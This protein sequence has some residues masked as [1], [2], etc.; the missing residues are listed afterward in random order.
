MYSEINEKIEKSQ[1]GIARLRKINSILKELESEQEDLLQKESDLKRVLKKEDYDLEK[2]EKKSIASLFYSILGSL[3]EHVEKERREALSA[4]LRYDQAIKDLENVKFQISKLSSERMDYVNCQAEY[5]Q[6]CALKKEE[7]I[8]EN[9]ET[10]KRIF[11]LSNKLNYAKINLKEIEEAIASGNEV[12]N[13][14]NKVL[15]SLDSA[16]GWGTWDLFGG[17]LLS[18]LAKHSHIN[19][20]SSEVENTQDLIHQFKTELTDIRISSDIAIEID[21]FAKFADFFFDGLIADWYMQSRIN[22]SQASVESVNSQVL[23]VLDELE[24]LKVQEIAGMERLETELSEL[25][26]KA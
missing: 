26:I 1:Q 3:D 18:D 12:L 13:S 19:D 25:I 2:L 5:D 9:G 15:S 22:E 23:N 4:K 24:H 8:Q 14:L 7:L 11:E 21:G 16:E 20:A 10:A 6:L 17:G